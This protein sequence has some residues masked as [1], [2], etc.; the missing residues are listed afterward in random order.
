MQILAIIRL[1]SN[2]FSLLVS[3]CGKSAGIEFEPVSYGYERQMPA[4]FSP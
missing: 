3:N 4:S 1:K 2:S